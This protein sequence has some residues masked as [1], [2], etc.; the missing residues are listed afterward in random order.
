MIIV[1]RQA[2][3]DRAFPVV[4]GNREYQDQSVLLLAMDSVI[5]TSG[6]HR[7]PSDRADLGP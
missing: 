5:A 4:L 1:P 2:K 3:F 6:M 7:A